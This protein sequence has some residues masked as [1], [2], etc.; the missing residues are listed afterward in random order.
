MQG[1]YKFYCD[2]GRMGDLEGIF[3]ADS[4][5]VD[6]LVGKTVY[7]GEVLG[8]HSDIRVEITGKNVWLLTDDEDFISKAVEYGLSCS[9]YDPV[10][11]Y[12]MNGGD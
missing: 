2:C 9:G 8:K 4:S 11:Y 3:L 6:A 10:W 5:E 7:F 1:L 12:E